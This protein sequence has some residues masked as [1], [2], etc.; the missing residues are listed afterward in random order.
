MPYDPD[1]RSFFTTILGSVAALTVLGSDQNAQKTNPLLLRPPGA[2]EQDLTNKCLRCGECIRACPTGALQPSIL[3]GGLE[4]IFTPL[5]IPRLGYCDFSCNRCG[6]VCPVEAITPLPLEEKRKFVIGWAFIDEN[7]C[8]PWADGTPCIVCEE[9]C[10]VPEKAIL[11]EEKQVTGP[12][13]SI[14]VIQLP[15][16]VRELCIGCG[17]CEYKC[18]RTGIAAIRVFRADAT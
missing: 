18:P 11:L 17:I 16:V 8:I 9:M 6:E 15:R 1:R 2:V 3:D 13:D 14:N 10:P 4:R 5:L 12:D 7:L